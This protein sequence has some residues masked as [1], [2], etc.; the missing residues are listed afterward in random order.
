VE[1]E[2]RGSDERFFLLFFFS[3]VTSREKTEWSR[4]RGEREREEKREEEGGG[5][6][7]R[8]SIA[9]TFSFFQFSTLS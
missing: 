7:R 4:N 8:F 3:L 6:R 1:Q 5:G 2:V 9:F